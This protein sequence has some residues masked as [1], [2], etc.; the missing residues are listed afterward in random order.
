MAF[1][2]RWSLGFAQ[3]AMA[4]ADAEAAQQR[5]ASF[6]DRCAAEAVP[7]SAFHSGSPTDRASFAWHLPELGQLHEGSTI[8]DNN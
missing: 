2:L 1:G 3:T 6:I 4:L 8:V 7:I 5:M